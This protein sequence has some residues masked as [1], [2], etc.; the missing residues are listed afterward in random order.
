[1]L[2]LIH[3]VV[4]EAPVPLVAKITFPV[5]RIGERLAGVAEDT[6]FEPVLGIVFTHEHMGRGQ[7]LCQW[8]Y[9]YAISISGQNVWWLEVGWISC[10]WA[11]ALVLCPCCPPKAEPVLT[12]FACTIATMAYVILPIVA[13][14][15][16]IVKLVLDVIFQAM[17]TCNLRFG[18]QYGRN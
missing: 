8:R 7:R 12:P 10:L 13:S 15:A 6:F 2:S 14:R 11:I 18:V 5:A 4:A 17:L 3:T 9:W 1:M 16:V